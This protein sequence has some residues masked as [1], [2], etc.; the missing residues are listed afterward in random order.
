[1]PTYRDATS[2]DVWDLALLGG[3]AAGLAIVD[4]LAQHR[5]QKPL[6]ILVCDDRTPLKDQ[7]HDRTWCFW[8]KTDN[9]VDEAV[10]KKW[11]RLRIASRH[12]DRIVHTQPYRYA[13]ITSDSY[14][15]LVS[16]RLDLAPHLDV[17]W[18]GHADNITPGHYSTRVEVDNTHFDIPAVFDS[19]PRATWPKHDTMLWQHFYGAFVE[20]QTDVFD[21]ATATLMDFAIPQPQVGTAFGYVL[22]VSKR[23][24]LIEYT[25]FSPTMLTDAQYREAWTGYVHDRVG[26]AV[27]TLTVVAEET[28]C[29]PMTDAHLE[30]CR[31]SFR[32]IGTAGGATRASTGYTF[33]AMQRRGQAIADDLFAGRGVNHDA[34]YGRRYEAMDAL[35]LKALVDGRIDGAEFF[36]RLFARNSASRVFGYLDGESRRSDDVALM[37]S[38]PTGPMLATV[39]SKSLQRVRGIS[40]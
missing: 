17:V 28:G 39:G 20:A 16:E 29:I 36:D 14:Y 19:R 27:D 37:S 21:P 18:T 1:M 8:D 13:L 22:P 9:S 30:D 23:R 31:G 3:G 6:R 34:H 11:T 40:Q 2:T 5:T 33:R 35:M 26:V 38:S 10:T 12:Y 15:R 7:Q 25:E 4:A 24:A 32:R